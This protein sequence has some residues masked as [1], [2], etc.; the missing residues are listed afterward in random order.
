MPDP[1]QRRAQARIRLQNQLRHR[2]TKDGEPPT[3]EQ[4]EQICE[5]DVKRLVA[6][7]TF[8]TEMGIPNMV[9]PLWTHLL[10]WLEEGV[11]RI[12]VTGGPNRRPSLQHVRRLHSSQAD[13]LQ[14]IEEAKSVLANLQ[15]LVQQLPP[16]HRLHNP[17]R[18][19]LRPTHEVT[20]DEVAHA[21]DHDDPRGVRGF[22]SAVRD[23]ERLGIPLPPHIALSILSIGAPLEPRD[24]E[25]ALEVME[26]SLT[27][28]K[29]DQQQLSTT[30]GQRKATK[31]T[32]TRLEKWIDHARS[33]FVSERTLVN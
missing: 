5:E 18:L 14:H 27:E 17:G 25:T 21:N 31:A 28:Y 3:L 6:H 7:I 15:A 24:C 12:G 32:V 23:F 33:R 26:K 8:V 16:G 4:L 9:A 1:A 29:M 13:K 19:G 20:Q 22:Q 11:Q 10:Y 2:K 30:F